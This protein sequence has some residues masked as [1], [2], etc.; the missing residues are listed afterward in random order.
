MIRSALLHLPGICARLRGNRIDR[1]HAVYRFARGPLLLDGGQSGGH[2]DLS[3]GLGAR[4]I[5]NSV[6]SLAVIMLAAGLGTGVGDVAMNIQETSSSSATTRSSCRSGTDSSR[7]AGWPARW[8]A[9]WLLHSVCRSLATFDSI[10]PLAGGDVDGDSVLRAGCKIA[11]GGDR[12]NRKS[13]SLTSR[14]SWRA[15]ARGS[16]V[17]IVDHPCGNPP[18]H[19]CVW[20]RRW[21]GRRMIGSLSSWLTTGA[22]RLPSVP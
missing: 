5:G 16:P 18:R 3:C 9:P 11:P 10:A 12:L 8:R 6:P 19:Y 1:F 7:L 22:R 15:S 4:A 20:H 13:P 17:A 14:S 2:C 21:R